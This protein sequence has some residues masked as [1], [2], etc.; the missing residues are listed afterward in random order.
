MITIE[1]KLISILAS[2]KLACVFLISH[3]GL[4]NPLD[5]PHHLRETDVSDY[6]EGVTLDKPVKSG[7][8]A[9]ANV[10][11]KKVSGT[12]FLH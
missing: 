4:L 5:I 1:K 10:G 11:L 3:V 6:R 7:K 2:V 9:Y 12:H 8:G